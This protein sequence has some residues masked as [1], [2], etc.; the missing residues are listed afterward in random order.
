MVSP[1]AFVWIMAERVGCLRGWRMEGVWEDRLFSAGSNGGGIVGC[2]DGVGM[3]SLL[4]L[5]WMMPDRVGC[6][7]GWKMEGA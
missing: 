3:V 5:V 7:R 1:L 2:C 4:A 6:L